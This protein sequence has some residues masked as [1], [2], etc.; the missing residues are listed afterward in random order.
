MLANYSL[1]EDMLSHFT[2]IIHEILAEYEGNAKNELS[3]Y[4]KQMTIYE[5]KEHNVKVRYGLGEISKDVFS[6]T[7]KDLS[8][9]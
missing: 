1:S 3:Q 5:N 2:D 6:A 8:D 4:Q 7:I 9:R